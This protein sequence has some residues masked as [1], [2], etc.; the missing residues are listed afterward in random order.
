MNKKRFFYLICFLCFA[1]NVAGQSSEFSDQDGAA[2]EELPFNDPPYWRHALNGT[3]IGS[4]ASQAESVVI[5]SD[6]GSVRAF[7][8][9]GRHLWDYTVNGRLQPFVTLSRE[10]T[11]YVCRLSGQSGVLIAINRVGRELW[12]VNLGEP[13]SAPVIVGWDGRLFVFTERHIRCFT[14]A[15]H[16]LWSRPLEKNIA[17]KPQRDGEGGF[18]LIYEDMEFLRFDAFGKVVFSEKLDS[19]PL[20]IVPL[21]YPENSGNSSVENKS[22]LFLYSNGALELQNTRDGSREALSGISLPALPHSLAGLDGHA[23]VLLKNGSICY[24]SIAEQAILWTRNT[25]LSPGNFIGS[26][27]ETD[28]F[29]DERGVYLLTQNGAVAFT[30]DGFRLWLIE[31]RGTV[32]LP[33]FSDEGILYSGGT[34]WILYAYKL[35]ERVKAQK[36][37]MYGPAPE[38]NY[39]TGVLRY[40]V[41]EQNRQ[42]FSEMEL[43]PQFREI[44]TAARD[45]S[46]GDREKEYAA[47]LMGVAGSSLGSIQG[48]LLPGNPRPGFQS[49]VI[50]Q[51]KLRA[52]RLL[53]LMGARETVPLLANLFTRDSDPL[54]KAAAAEAIGTIGTDP[55]GIAL[56][57]F[58]N[59][60]F[61]LAPLRDEQAL[62]AVAA[63]T[64]AI[65]RFSGPPLSEAGIRILAGLSTPDRPPIVRN[66]ADR[67]LRSLLF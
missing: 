18:F 62:S 32:S 25:H 3:V 60:I 24:I 64:G 48:N 63:A 31:L 45:G 15:G 55:E 34:N 23:A 51:Y 44:E 10:G 19:I 33:A 58:T 22:L 67:E 2:P 20:A 43:I 35:E 59:A 6:G 53:A 1:M 61:P 42:R 57:A 14:A 46:I 36:R 13:L 17:F 29:F 27:P 12:Q 54:V 39:G 65:C 66:T 40:D 16:A 52:I 50:V 9:H 5:V 8:L 56:Q 37:V 11:A 21:N 4:P 7:S 28:F 41:W 26:A 47:W 30:E 38:G 49:P